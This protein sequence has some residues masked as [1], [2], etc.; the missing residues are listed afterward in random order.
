MLRLSAIRR[1]RPPTDTTRGTLLMNSQIPGPAG[2]A[3]APACIDHGTLARTGM[4]PPAPTGLATHGAGDDERLTEALRQLEVQAANFGTRFIQ[5]SRVRRQYIAES[6]RFSAE[7]LASVR[8]GEISVQQAHLIAHE[9]R[10]TLL[11]AS[12]L[13]TSDIGRAYAQGLKAANPGL[14]ALYAKYA[15]ELYR[16]PFETLEYAQRNDVKLKIIESAG[17]NR[18]GPTRIAGRLGTLG[19]GLWVLTL[20]IAVY[21]VAAAE[22]RTEAVAHEGATLGGGMAGAAA[23][24]AAAG[25]ACGPGAVVC[26]SVLVIAGGALGALGMSHVFDWIWE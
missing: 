11:E 15:R 5:D 17:R 3:T 26:S 24:G 18:P 10:G 4:T 8:R 13:K 9:M 12:R 2:V 7:L 16:Q 14:D 21:N 6:R 19:R 22:D 1:R 20:G 23:A 25:L